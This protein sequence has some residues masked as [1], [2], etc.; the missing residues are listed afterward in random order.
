M[1]IRFPDLQVLYP[2]AQQIAGKL[3]QAQHQPA[4]EQA[5]LA[6][7]GAAEAVRRNQQVRRAPVSEEARLEREGRQRHRGRQQALATTGKP[8]GTFVGET[9]QHLDIQG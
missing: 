5:A 1:S 6:A 9:G 7:Q 4:V 3:Q 8:R 2:R